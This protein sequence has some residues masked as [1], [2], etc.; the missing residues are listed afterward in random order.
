MSDSKAAEDFTSSWGGGGG[1]MVFAVCDQ[2]P[3]GVSVVQHLQTGSERSVTALH[4]HSGAV[5]QDVGAQSEEHFT[6]LTSLVI[7]KTKRAGNSPA[8]F[9]DS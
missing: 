1:W 4:H 2:P 8:L 9:L 3:H 7:V 6:C 5:Q